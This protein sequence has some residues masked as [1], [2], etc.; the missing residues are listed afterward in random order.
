MGCINTNPVIKVNS[1]ESFKK[2]IKKN[3]KQNECEDLEDKILNFSDL[4]AEN[5]NTS[6][7]IEEEQS[8]ILID[9][10]IENN[11]LIFL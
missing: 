3:I 2:E 11:E 9:A 5:I 1:I 8:Q 4:I 6:N 10:K 7:N